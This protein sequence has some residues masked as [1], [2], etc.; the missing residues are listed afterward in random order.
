MS[1]TLAKEY[2]D[3]QFIV[4]ELPRVEEKGVAELPSDMSSRVSFQV[5][6]MFKEQ[7][8]EGADVY[9]YRW[10]FHNWSDKYAIK[11][12]QALI[13]A[14]KSGARVLINDY[15]IPTGKAMSGWEEKQLR[16]A[17]IQNI[18]RLNHEMTNVN[19]GQWICVFGHC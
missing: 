6:D 2:P 18:N 15:C 10:I 9:Y 19:I 3:L 7:P 12:L 17:V 11:M 5:H 13:P 14:L 16:L 8:V 1:I 4:Q